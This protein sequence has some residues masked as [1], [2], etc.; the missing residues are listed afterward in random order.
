MWQCLG[1]GLLFAAIWTNY[2][3][4]DYYKDA[5]GNKVNVATENSLYV[6]SMKYWVYILAALGIACLSWGLW[7]ASH[8]KHSF[9]QPVLATYIYPENICTQ[10]TI[11]LYHNVRGTSSYT[12]R[13]APFSRRLI[14][15]AHDNLRVQKF[16]ALLRRAQQ[17]GYCCCPDETYT[18]TFYKNTQKFDSYAVDTIEFADKVRIYQSSYQFSYIVDKKEWINYLSQLDNISFN[19]Y[20]LDLK[21]ARKVYQYTLRHNLPVVTSSRVSPEWMNYDGDF[22]VKIATVGAKL[23]EK[24]IRE[25]IRKSY[26]HEQYKMDWVSRYQ[27]CGH[28]N[29]NDCYEEFVFRIYCDKEFYDKFQIYTPKSFY[30]SSWAEFLVLGSRAELDKIDKIAEKEEHDSLIFDPF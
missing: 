16:R 4:N 5:E 12:D 19:E 28:S 10:I 2:T 15:E 13:Y 26:P 14:L 20:H 17:T 11:S 6:I 27:V 9:P 1:A 18:I 8:K 23:D 25:N 21:E 22:K 30:D 3:K 29:G 7:S 24:E